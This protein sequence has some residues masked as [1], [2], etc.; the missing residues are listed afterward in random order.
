[1]F[2]SLGDRLI[3]SVPGTKDYGKTF[4]ALQAFQI[5]ADK[6][7]E[8]ELV[9][10]LLK[11][12]NCYVAG[13]PNQIFVQYGR[14]IKEGL[15][16]PCL[17]SAFANDYRGYVPVPECFGEP[18]VYEAR[19][20]PTSCLEPAAGDKIVEGILQLAEKIRKKEQLL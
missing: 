12:G 16:K 1:M 19:L 7:T 11:I 18:G 20:A 17:V 3:E 10:Q 15:G 9:L 2:D 6:R 5:M 8:C 13:T 4:Y 14:K